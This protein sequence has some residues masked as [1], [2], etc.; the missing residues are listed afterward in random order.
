LVPATL[1]ITIRHV[2]VS[3]V[4]LD[5]GANVN[6]TEQGHSIHFDLLARNGYLGVVKRL[7]ERGT[8]MQAVNELG[9]TQ[10]FKC[11]V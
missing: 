3:L 6:A 1:G 2:E 8:D 10:S 5:H 9:E 4:L 7:L 11:D